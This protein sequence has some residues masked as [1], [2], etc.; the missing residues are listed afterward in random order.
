MLLIIDDL[1]DNQTGQMRYRWIAPVLMS[2]LARNQPSYGA[3]TVHQAKALRGGIECSRCILLLYSCGS[4]Y[5]WVQEPVM[6]LGSSRTGT[7]SV[8][9]CRI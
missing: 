1:V 7:L 5:F 8:S 2:N 4:I 9:H 6:A 3:M